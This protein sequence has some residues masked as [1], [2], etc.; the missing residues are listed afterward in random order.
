MDNDVQQKENFQCTNINIYIHRNV[1]Y[2]HANV[3][4]LKFIL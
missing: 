3:L 1:T 2:V 4:V